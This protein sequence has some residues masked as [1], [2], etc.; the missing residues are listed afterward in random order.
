VVITL[1]DTRGG[2]GIGTIRSGEVVQ[3]V[4]ITGADRVVEFDQYSPRPQC[5]PPPPL[6]APG[7]V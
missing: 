5:R 3:E 4:D 7:P 2:S 6:P 1:P